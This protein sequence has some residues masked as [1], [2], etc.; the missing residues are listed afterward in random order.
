MTSIVLE[1]TDGT[2]VTN[3]V[4]PKPAKIAGKGSAA[5]TWIIKI[6]NVV[7]KVVEDPTL[8]CSIETPELP[9]GGL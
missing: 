9:P 5:R 8:P 7:L 2:I 6:G 4:P 1:L 3:P